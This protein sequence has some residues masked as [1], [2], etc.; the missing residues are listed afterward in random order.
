M[1]FKCVSLNCNGLRNREKRIELFESFRKKDYDCVFLQETFWDRGIEST[2]RDEWRGKCISSFYPQNKRRGVSILFKKDCGFDIINYDTDPNGRY[3]LVELCIDHQQFTIVNIYAPN[4]DSER[5][6]FFV[7]I[8]GKIQNIHSNIILVGDFNNVIN[9]SLD[10]YPPNHVSDPSRKSLHDL[11]MDLKILDIWREHNPNKVVFSRYRHTSS[12][13]TASRIDRYLISEDLRNKV[14]VCRYSPYPRSDHDFVEITLD[15]NLIPRGQSSW[16]FNNTLLKDE[17]YCHIIREIIKSMTE[18]TMFI[19]DIFEW[20]ETFK[21]RIKD[22]SIKYSKQ[23]NRQTRQVRKKLT[24]QINHEREKAQKYNDY[25]IG[26][27]LRLESEL[28]EITL[29]DMRGAALRAK[30]QWYE[31]GE[32]STKFF[33]SIEKSRQR[34]KVITKLVN[35]NGEI[36]QDQAKIVDEQINFYRRLYKHEPVDLHSQEELVNYISR[37]LPEADVNSCDQELSVLELKEALFKMESN[38]SPGLDGLTAEFYKY[39]WWD[40]I[41]IFQKLIGEIYNQNQLCN[42]MKIGLITL[43]PKKGDLT[44]LENWR[45]I[46]LLNIDY[47]IISKALAS[48]ISKVMHHLV[49]ADQTCSVPGRDIGENVLAMSNIIEYVNDQH[50]G[51][52]ALK[53]DQAKAFDRINHGY[54]FRVIEEMGFGPYLLKWVK[55]LYSNILACIKHN[56]FISDT[57]IIERGVR[58][59]CPLSP[60]LYVLSAEP[61]HESICKSPSISGIEIGNVEAKMFQHADDTTFFISNVKSVHNILQV[62]RL[63]ELAS[64]SKC[65]VNKT[66]LLV[67]GNKNVNPQDFNFP[68]RKDFITVLGVAIGNSKGLLATE[69]WD[70]KV[71]NCISILRRWQFRKLSFKGKVLVVNSLVLSKLVYLASVLPIPQWVITTIRKSVTEFLWNGKQPLISYSTLILPID[72][73]GLNLGDLGIKRDSLRVKYIGKLFNS[74]ENSM[75]KSS[76][77]YFLNRYENMNLGLSI[78]NIITVETELFRVHPFYKEMLEAWN[79]LTDGQYKEP[80]AREDMLFQP[81]FRNPFIRDELESTLFIREFIDGGI[82]FV[83]DLMYEILPS[84]LPIQA[85]HECIVLTNPDNLL[86]INETECYVSII[87]NALP[88]DWIREIFSS[89]QVVSTQSDFEYSVSFM[90]H[91]ETLDGR[92]LSCKQAN[93]VFRVNHGYIPKGQEHWSK[94]FTDLN[95][96]KRWENIYKSPKCFIDADLDFKILHNILFTNEKLFKCNMIDS[97]ICTLC[98]HSDETNMHLFIE[99]PKVNSLWKH[100]VSKFG[101]LD[102]THSYDD[103]R[104][105]TLFGSGLPRKNKEGILIDF[106]FNIYKC[107]I[108]S[109]RNQINAKGGTI[110]VAS[111]FHHVMKNKINIIFETYCKN[112]TVPSFFILFAKSNVLLSQEQDYTYNYQLDTG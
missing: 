60:I 78:F 54:L 39:F 95:F 57:F 45:P 52:L 15:L 29:N 69:N 30:I 28:N 72:K 25:D 97:P 106:I 77:I 24:K 32:K 17:T 42:S 14:V 80:V 12:A 48:R 109:C 110:H 76:S 75:F 19:E 50:L 90:R 93:A 35:V 55:I 105:M 73:G 63:Y 83:S 103:W 66:E 36:I 79:K 33:Y 82:I 62:I 7:E 89:D 86:S 102:E 92:N 85:I 26:K 67:I 61:F 6:H 21:I 18:E 46:S 101:R 74:E 20:Y 56:G 4:C 43:I 58:Q 49:S 70:N 104:M 111:Y 65:N 10:R 16:I 68:V 8:Y 51:G 37:I 13:Y 38:K 84:H 108:W 98:Q 81:I 9:N 94:L 3:V 23:K 47:K 112:H 22:K 44:K 53:I 5:K 59:G 107:V 11:M 64:G 87:M 71:Q 96:E 2:V 27:L 1:T 91:G 31:E 99:C 88:D 40:L 34:K 100:L 41:N